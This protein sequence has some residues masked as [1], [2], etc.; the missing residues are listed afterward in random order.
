MINYKN[1]YHID[2]IVLSDFCPNTNKFLS[3]EKYL[4]F[5][6]YLH[7]FHPISELY[8]YSI[9]SFSSFIIYSILM[10]SLELNKNILTYEKYFY[11][12]INNFSRKSNNPITTSNIAKYWSLLLQV[13]DQL[14]SITTSEYSKEV[15]VLRKVCKPLKFINL[16]PVNQNFYWE[17]PVQ[18]INTDNTIHNIVILPYLSD[19]NILSNSVVLNTIDL[20]PSSQTLS[21]VQLMLDKVMLNFHTINLTDYLFKNIKEYNKNFYIDYSKANLN[22][23]IIC[24]ANPCDNKL[25]FSLTAPIHNNVRKIKMVEK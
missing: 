12:V 8:E 5:K 1:M 19:Q 9:T 3:N 2:D 6:K 25:M 21:V 20:Y 23:C 13:Y 18:I 7:T 16:T 11:N 22:Q 15:I 10:N 24:P 4:N 17:I 14:I